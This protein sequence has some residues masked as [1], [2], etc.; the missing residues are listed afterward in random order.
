MF[1]NPHK[2]S[3]PKN[4]SF[5]LTHSIQSRPVVFFYLLLLAACAPTPCAGRLDR[6]LAL[7]YEIAALSGLAA[8][9]Y[10]AINL[11]FLFV[12]LVNFRFPRNVL[13]T[14]VADQVPTQ[15][16]VMGFDAHHAFEVWV[17]DKPLE[18]LLFHLV[19][20][21]IFRTNSESLREEIYATVEFSDC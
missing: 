17:H 2:C 18:K 20:R 13:A 12:W 7:A 1:T 4:K 16:V 21:V 11:E 6:F 9:Q 15:L 10:N 14:R 3:S 8:R 5:H 19:F